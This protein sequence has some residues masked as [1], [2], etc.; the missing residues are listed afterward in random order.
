MK[1][2][3]I[4]VYTILFDLNDSDTEEVFKSC[5][6]SPTEPYFFVAPDGDDLE[7]AFGDIAQDLVNLHVSR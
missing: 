7:R 1:K 5:A 6:T 2:D 4:L 3:G